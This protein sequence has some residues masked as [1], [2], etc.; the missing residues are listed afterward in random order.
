[1]YNDESTSSIQTISSTKI[2][3]IV[4]EHNIDQPY[5]SYLIKQQLSW[6][7]KQNIPT[8]YVSNDLREWFTSIQGGFEH[9]V[10]SWLIEKENQKMKLKNR[11]NNQDGELYGYQKKICQAKDPDRNALRSLNQNIALMKHICQLKNILGIKFMYWITHFH[12]LHD[13]IYNYSNENMLITIETLIKNLEQELINKGITSAVVVINAVGNYIES[14]KEALNN[15]ALSTVDMSVEYLRILPTS[16]KEVKLEDRIAYPHPNLKLTIHKLHNRNQ[17]TPLLEPIQTTI[18]TIELKGATTF[19]TI[20]PI[21]VEEFM[22]QYNLLHDCLNACDLKDNSSLKQTIHAHLNRKIKNNLARIVLLLSNKLIEKSLLEQATLCLSIS[23]DLTEDNKIY[24]EFIR[25]NTY[26]LKIIYLKKECL[27]LFDQFKTLLDFLENALSLNENL[28]LA[29]IETLS[30]TLKHFHKMYPHSDDELQ[31]LLKLSFTTNNLQ[32]ITSTVEAL[33]QTKLSEA[34][35]NET[36]EKSNLSSPMQQHLKHFM[37]L[38]ILAKNMMGREEVNLNDLWEIS[39]A[40]LD[41]FIK[42][43]ETLQPHESLNEDAKNILLLQQLCLSHMGTTLM[44]YSLKPRST[45][46]RINKTLANLMLASVQF[47]ANCTKSKIDKAN[48]DLNSHESIIKILSDSLASYGGLFLMKLTLTEDFTQQFTIAKKLISMVIIGINAELLSLIQPVALESKLNFLYAR[49]IHGY[50]MKI[51]LNTESAGNCS[52]SFGFNEV[53]LRYCDKV[54]MINP[55]QAINVAEITFDNQSNILINLNFYL[56]IKLNHRQLISECSTAFPSALMHYQAL[57]LKYMAKRLLSINLLYQIP[58]IKHQITFNLNAKIDKFNVFL[59]GFFHGLKCANEIFSTIKLTLS[60][61]KTFFTLDL[62]ANHQRISEWLQ[63]INLSADNLNEIFDAAQEIVEL[64][65]L[66]NHF[67][68]N[69]KTLQS[70][71]KSKTLPLEILFDRITESNFSLK[72][73]GKQTLR[74]EWFKLPE[75]GLSEVQC[76]KFYLTTDRNGKKRK[77][78]STELILPIALL[79]QSQDDFSNSFKALHDKLDKNG[80]S[81]HHNVSPL[82]SILTGGHNDGSSSSS[83]STT[84]NEPSCSSNQGFSRVDEES[85]EPNPIDDPIKT[86]AERVNRAFQQCCNHLTWTY[87]DKNIFS[88]SLNKLTYEITL[89]GKRSSTHTLDRDDLIEFMQKSLFKNLLSRHTCRLWFEYEKL[90]S[91][92]KKQLQDSRLCFRGL[93]DFI[94]NQLRQNALPEPS[95]CRVK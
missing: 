30:R 71:Q 42:Y 13:S 16:S 39:N 80:V 84:I 62:S 11:M 5:V 19:N 26:L 64:K 67:I 58:N 27:D 60:L 23:L 66:F 55:I 48:I 65:I 94:S 47:E 9:P 10:F 32:T 17:T 59:I 25:L 57:V 20:Q 91:T 31:R 49:Y 83:S 75:V 90:T 50:K 36:I 44:Y 61:D 29:C 41:E 70:Y 79:F 88:I 73:I 52:I 46:M 86:F 28:K 14:F 89:P 68:G 51:L 43:R 87:D 21:D 4:V 8:F 18:Q 1:M 45:I 74:E 35:I 78:V 53:D 3:F 37:M 93:T 82:L 54:R 81:N 2:H 34:A 6:L 63:S 7:E 56:F 72:Y 15:E 33:L 95:I 69:F 40:I 12:Q 92:L 22:Q 24:C 38:F 77:L 85:K 76:N